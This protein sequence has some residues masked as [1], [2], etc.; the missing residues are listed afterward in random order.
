M[1]IEIADATDYDV[2]RLVEIYS[3]PNLYHS[4]AEAIWFVKSF[5][6]YHHIK[7]AKLKGTIIGG[8]FWRGEAERHH[9][10]A[11]VDDLWIDEKFRRKG[12]GEKLLRT[13]IEDAK[14]FFE[15]DSHLLRKVLVTTG[16][17]NKPARKLYRKIGFKKCAVLKDL[18]DKGENELVY[19]LTLNP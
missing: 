16:Q 12:Y 6:D 3:S 7:V 19:I 8:L 17:D 11:V 18:Y 14:T 4:K 10:I 5:Y 15:K 2:N 13:A 9:G 1:D